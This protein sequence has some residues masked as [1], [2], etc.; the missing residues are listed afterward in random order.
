MSRRPCRNPG[1]GGRSRWNGSTITPPM[2]SWFSSIIAVVFSRSL[3]G[4][5]SIFSWID[6]GMPAESGSAVGKSKSFEGDM[7]IRA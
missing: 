5:M 1:L 6:L 2:S 3:K 4:A 7:L